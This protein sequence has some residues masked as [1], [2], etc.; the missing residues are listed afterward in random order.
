MPLMKSTNYI[1][2][3]INRQHSVFVANRLGAECGQ[4]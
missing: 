2:Y 4:N 1:G 3:I